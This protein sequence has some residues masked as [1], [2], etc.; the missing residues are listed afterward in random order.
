MAE[1]IIKTEQHL[2]LI[3]AW[4]NM[5]RGAKH[6]LCEDHGWVKQT[7]AHILRFGRKDE[8]IIEKLLVDIKVVSGEIAEIVRQ[9]NEIVQS[10]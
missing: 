4:E 1:E 3:E 8:S 10:I 5:P 7:V 6:K 2:K 9:E